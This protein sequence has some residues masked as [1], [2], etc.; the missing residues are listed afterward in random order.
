M[1]PLSPFGGAHHMQ[2]RYAVHASRDNFPSTY[3][4]DPASYPPSS[5]SIFICVPSEAITMELV[6]VRQ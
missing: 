1:V 5:P 3:V 4:D 6:H 2:S